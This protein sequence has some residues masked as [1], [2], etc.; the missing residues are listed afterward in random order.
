MAH[1]QAPPT[2]PTVPH[3]R[4]RVPVGPVTIAL[5]HKRAHKQ[6]ANWQNTIV[7]AGAVIGQQL[8]VFGSGPNLTF[9]Q[10]RLVFQTLN[11]K[12]RGTPSG[13]TKNINNKTLTT[14]YSNPMFLH[15]QDSRG[16]VI[17][18]E[19]SCNVGMHLFITYAVEALT[20]I[21]V[22]RIDQPPADATIDPEYLRQDLRITLYHPTPDGANT[23]ACIRG[24]A[25]AGLQWA[26]DL[27][28]SATHDSTMTESTVSMTD[29]KNI[30]WPIIDRN[31]LTVYPQDAT[32]NYCLL[33]HHELLQIM[34]S[35]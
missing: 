24:N 31:G 1:A 33:P 29:M 2:T 28:P 21:G 11:D 23:N 5:E 8:V 25:H 19:V 10:G 14:S 34:A 13:G 4:T 17:T 3:E 30:L 35:E 16:L 32:R 27:C 18:I 22:P 7:E 26:I 6:F 12:I 15:P 20:E 9:P